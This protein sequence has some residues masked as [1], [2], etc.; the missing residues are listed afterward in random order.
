VGTLKYSLALP[1]ISLPD[2]ALEHLHIVITRAFR[3]RQQFAVNVISGAAAPIQVW[4][5]ARVPIVVTYATRVGSS[6]NERWIKEL[7]ASLA[8]A[9]LVLTPE[10]DP[11]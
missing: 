10:P 11:A 6:I 2:R 4:L 7:E 3:E 5:D 8:G 1:A 9:I